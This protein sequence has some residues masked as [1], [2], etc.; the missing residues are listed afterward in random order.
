MANAYAFLIVMLAT[1]PTG[2]SF[3]A[4]LTSEWSACPFLFCQSR[5]KIMIGQKDRTQ[6]NE[7]YIFLRSIFLP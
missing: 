1:S 5:A 4:P 6:K 7:S 3:V 2:V